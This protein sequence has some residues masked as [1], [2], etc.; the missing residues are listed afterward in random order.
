MANKRSFKA[1]MS[2]D[3][4]KGIDSVIQNTE[5]PLNIPTRKTPPKRK[6]TLAD[7]G[8]E[9]ATFIVDIEL[10]DKIRAI[11]FWERLKIREIIEE[12]M[13]NYVTSYEETKGK[14]KAVP[15]TREKVFGKKSR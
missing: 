7:L 11:A 4:G 2:A 14:V 3:I 13:S 5:S 6:T 1:A 15:R 12:V 8:Q 10:H 9:R